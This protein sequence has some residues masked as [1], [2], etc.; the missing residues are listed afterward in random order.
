MFIRGILLFFVIM[1][2]FSIIPS[3]YG[4]DKI[5][6]VNNQIEELR[7]LLGGKVQ[8]EPKALQWNRYVTANFEILSLDDAQGRYLSQNIENIKTWIL[9]RWGIKDTDFS[10][11]CKIMCVPTQDLYEKL[12]NKKKSAWKVDKTGFNIWLITD[13][14]KWNTKLPE[15][16]TEVVLS[17]F[18]SIYKMKFPIWSRRGMSVLNGR[19][20][21]IK[22]LLPFVSG[23]S[24]VTFFS[25][26]QES[27][28][29]M[30]DDQ[31]FT[32][33]AQAAYF[34]LWIRKEINGKIF[35][36]FINGS[37]FGQERSLSILQ[38]TSYADCDLKF[39]G[40]LEKFP[41]NSDQYFTW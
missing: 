2:G 29:K 22:S 27:Y 8:P 5:D 4:Q 41:G 18:E 25:T 23:F 38:L 11:K 33:D 34:C 39:K 36:D 28:Q 7:K 9:W 21:D 37:L 31:K 26:T 10:A 17:N 19:I 24:A 13:G 1:F 35:L 40:Y 3:I 14:V 20:E 32:F 15:Q 16:L 30:S 12:F 6:N